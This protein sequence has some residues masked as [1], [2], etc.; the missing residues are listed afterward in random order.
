MLKPPEPHTGYTPKNDW[1]IIIA[2][3]TYHCIMANSM[4]IAS[5]YSQLS[6]HHERVLVD[7]NIVHRFQLL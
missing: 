4:H 6:G 2:M 1:C 7:F 3:R 5:L